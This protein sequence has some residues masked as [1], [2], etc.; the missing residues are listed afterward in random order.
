MIAI[1]DL[2]PNALRFEGLSAPELVGLLDGTTDIIPRDGPETPVPS[3]DEGSPVR[4]QGRV[5]WGPG[6]V[7]FHQVT[8]DETSQIMAVFERLRGTAPQT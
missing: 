3:D 8:P 5:L 6:F 7:A 4:S 2:T 1:N